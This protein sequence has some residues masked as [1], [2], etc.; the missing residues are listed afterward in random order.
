[1]GRGSP[2]ST[3]NSRSRVSRGDAAP[4]STSGSTVLRRFEPARAR[5]P[6]RVS[7]HVLHGV[8]RRVLQRV[9]P[10]HGFVTR[11]VTCQVEGRARQGRNR[12]ARDLRHLVGWRVSRCGP[13]DRGDGVRCSAISSICAVA[14]THCAP[15]SADAAAPAITPRRFDHSH[16]AT[17]RSRSDRSCLAEHVDV[18]KHAGIPA[19]QLVSRATGL[20]SDHDFSHVGSMPRGPDTRDRRHAT[21]KRVTLLRGVDLANERGLEPEVAKELRL[22]R[23]EDHVVRIGDGNVWRVIGNG[24]AA[25][26]IDP[27]LRS[28]V[29]PGD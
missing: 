15:C 8:G 7:H 9:E 24:G 12:N 20:A 21:K 29:P 18:R 22:V 16:A 13:A 3:S 26:G 19:G 10:S 17:V 14:S 6:L 11:Q 27:L 2:A 5:I 23:L 25:D 1:M 4:P 28:A